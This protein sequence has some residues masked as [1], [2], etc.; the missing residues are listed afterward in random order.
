MDD[1]LPRLEK[2]WKFSEFKRI[3]IINYRFLE[4]GLVRLDRPSLWVSVECISWSQY[5]SMLTWLDFSHKLCLD[6]YL[7]ALWL[8]RVIMTDMYTHLQRQ[9]SFT[10]GPLHV[11]W[12]V[13]FGCWVTWSISSWEEHYK[14]VVFFNFTKLQILNDL[15]IKK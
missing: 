11:L 7:L 10:Y 3:D 4:L 8:S 1:P 2:S 12:Q 6:T 9:L 13:S 14:S 15:K 5:W